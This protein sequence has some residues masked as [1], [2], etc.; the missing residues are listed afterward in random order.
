MSMTSKGKKMKSDLA[1]VGKNYLGWYVYRGSGLSW[2]YLHKCMSWYD[3]MGLS[4][5]WRTRREARELAKR[6]NNKQSSTLIS[7]KLCLGSN[8]FDDYWVSD[9]LVRS[10][11]CRTELAKH[12]FIPKNTKRIWVEASKQQ[13]KDNSGIKIQVNRLGYCWSNDKKNFLCIE[14][15]NYLNNN[16][17]IEETEWTTLYFR[18][19]VEY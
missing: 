5:Y 2:F 1:R 11:L 4:C 9:D 3:S 7:P 13:W 12:V 14:Q 8:L 6:H 16:G 15:I 17:F 19:W 10:W 18:V